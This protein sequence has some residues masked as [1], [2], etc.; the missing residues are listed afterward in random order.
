MQLGLVSSHCQKTD[1][2]TL[3]NEVSFGEFT[4]R[5]AH[6]P[7]LLTW[8]DNE[9]EK[10]RWFGGTDGDGL[11]LDEVELRTSRLVEPANR[12]D[13]LRSRLLDYPHSRRASITLV[14]VMS[15]PRW[16]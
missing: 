5:V 3:S 14:Y 4:F 13:M 10:W 6:T 16:S 15:L 7:S 12:S 1:P 9:R 8:S 11:H 2:E